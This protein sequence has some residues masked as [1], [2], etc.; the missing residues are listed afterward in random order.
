M[1]SKLSITKWLY[2]FDELWQRFLV[3]EINTNT[4]QFTEVLRRAQFNQNKLKYT[5]CCLIS[6]LVPDL[7][8]FSFLYIGTSRNNSN[9]IFKRLLI[10]IN[11]LSV[12][13]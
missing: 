9:I 4:F 2:S 8:R 13:Y 3:L 5:T 1:F 6:A 10:L 12:K 11:F 7:W